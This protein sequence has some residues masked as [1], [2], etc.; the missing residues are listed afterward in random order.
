MVAA[1]APPPT[2]APAATVVN[3]DERW[4]ANAQVWRDHISSLSKGLSK[5]QATKRLLEES[6]YIRKDTVLSNAIDN[7]AFWTWAESA[8]FLRTVDGTLM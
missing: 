7:G 1:A 3:F 4:G 5:E 8:N 6:E 2:P